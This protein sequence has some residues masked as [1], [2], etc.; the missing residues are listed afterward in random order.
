MD[1]NRDDISETRYNLRLPA[2]RAERENAGGGTIA[3]LSAYFQ[4]RCVRGRANR[5]LF[6]A[7]DTGYLVGL[8][9][10]LR[11]GADINVTDFGWTP[12]NW[13]VHL[14]TL[15]QGGPPGDREVVGCPDVIIELLAAGADPN[16]GHEAGSGLRIAAYGGRKDVVLM[17]LRAGAH[18]SDAFRPDIAVRDQRSVA[19]WGGL[20]MSWFPQYNTGGDLYARTYLH[21]VA[22]AGGFGTYKDVR[23]RELVA[24]HLVVRERRLPAEILDMTLDFL[25]HRGYVTVVMYPLFGIQKRRQPSSKKSKNSHRMFFMVKHRTPLSGIFTPYE[26]RNPGFQLCYCLPG[27]DV[28]LDR[29]SPVHSAEL[30]DA[31]KSDDFARNFAPQIHI[32]AHNALDARVVEIVVEKLPGGCRRLA[33]W[34]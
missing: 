32:E 22:H 30:D 14:M 4:Q 31:K 6:T 18:V 21:D 11:R 29:A 8:R 23:Y 24:A 7:V 33:R 13:A 26:Q 28:F 25:L 1:V 12:L 16:E 9:A 15:E 10:A 17:L 2:A 5:R 20:A 34:R 27:S 19:P 3:T